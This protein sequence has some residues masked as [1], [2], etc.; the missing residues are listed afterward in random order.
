MKS[1]TLM[2]VTSITLFIA[3]TIPAQLAAQGHTRYQLIDIGTLGGPVSYRS[4]D[5]EGQRELNNRGMVVGTA[6][7][8]TPDPNA[9]NPDLCVNLDCFLSHAIQWQNG[10]L[11][12]TGTRPWNTSNF[13]GAC[14]E[15]SDRRGRSG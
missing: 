7:T 12:S 9:A 4:G 13:G 1:R 6:D 11:I 14:S 15:I 8:S 3:L 10:V 2:C 5:G